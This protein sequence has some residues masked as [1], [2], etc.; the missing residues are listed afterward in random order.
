MVVVVAVA[1]VL[2]YHQMEIMVVIVQI[3]M[4]ALAV[5]EVL[6]VVMVVVLVVLVVLELFQEVV[7]AVMVLGQDIQRVIEVDMEE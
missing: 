6:L 7:V 1:E 3:Y 2:L 4:V 5:L